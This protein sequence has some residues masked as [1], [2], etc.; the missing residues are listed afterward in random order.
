MTKKKRHEKKRKK[1]R[2]KKKT[3]K[4]RGGANECYICFKDDLE[5]NNN[6]IRL[7][8]GHIFCKNCIRPWLINNNTCPNCRR[9]VSQEDRNRVG[10]LPEI[11]EYTAVPPL[12][13]VQRHQGLID[14]MRRREEERQ[15]E[16]EEDYSDD[17]EYLYDFYHNINDIVYIYE[18]DNETEQI[19][20]NDEINGFNIQDNETL[21][22][23]IHYNHFSLWRIIARELVENDFPIY[24]LQSV[25]D[26]NIVIIRTQLDVDDSVSRY[27]NEV[28]RRHRFWFGTGGKRK[29]KTRKR[30]KKKRK[31]TRKKQKK[32]F[33]YNPNDPSKSFDVYI[34]KNPNDTI[35]IKYTTVKDVEKTI[36]KLERLYKTKKYP[37]KRIWQVGMIMKVRLEAMD[38]YK[39]TKFK[40]AKNVNKRYRLAKKYFKFL[41]DRTK[42]KTFLER[43]KMIFKLNKTKKK[44]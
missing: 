11:L 6:N 14:T 36:R 7:S 12:E 27:L 22:N 30:R 28:R 33:L 20:S 9:Q 13:Y 26:N 16:D 10:S 35:P 37:H 43:K 23:T 32:Q 3:R 18:V 40:N 29:K 21:L 31:K 24:T 41:G 5:E 4:R 44:N 15:E 2:R 38:K 42:K 25:D 8:C 1:T 19:L 17:D 34:D 39:K